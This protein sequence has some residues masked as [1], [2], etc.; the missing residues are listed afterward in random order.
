MKILLYEQ[1]RFPIVM[2]WATLIL[3]FP[4]SHMHEIIGFI[5]AKLEVRKDGLGANKN[6]LCQSIT[7][8]IP[9]KLQAS[10]QS[11]S[12]YEAAA[13]YMDR[14]I[15]GSLP[16]TSAHKCFKSVWSDFLPPLCFSTHSAPFHLLTGRT[17][18]YFVKLRQL[19]AGKNFC[20]H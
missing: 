18:V 19:L 8:E 4:N 6:N 3:P 9:V 1:K 16:D 5:L 15:L 12:Q 10:T 11:P 7:I 2:E 14:F 17:K 13:F 20:L